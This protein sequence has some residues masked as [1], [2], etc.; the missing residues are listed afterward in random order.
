M[1]TRPSCW[2]KMFGL[3]GLSAPTLGLCL[4]FFSSITTDFNIPSALRWVIQERWSSGKGENDVSLLSVTVNSIFI[5]LT[6]NKDRHKIFEWVWISAR[7]DQPLWS[8][9]PLSGEKNDV[10]SFSH[11]PLI[12]Y[13][14]NLQVRRT[15]KK[16]SMSWNLDRIRLFT[17]ELFTLDC[18]IYFPSLISG[19]RL[20]SSS[21]NCLSCFWSDSFYTYR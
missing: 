12:R 21:A 2:H 16:A 18:R 3:N 6:G 20:L 11:S 15:G 8:Y 9:L 1:V 19:E 5:K 4:N 10:S 14:S 17:L 7:S 13:L